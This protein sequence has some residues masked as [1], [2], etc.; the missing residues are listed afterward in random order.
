SLLIIEYNLDVVSAADW[1]IDIGPE[2]GARGGRLVAEGTPAQFLSDRQGLTADA[3]RQ[4]RQDLE[5]SRQHTGKKTVRH[6]GQTTAGK[7]RKILPVIQI[8]H[9]REHNLK[10]IDLS[11]PWNTFTVITGVS[12]SGKSTIAFDIIFAEG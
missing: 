11:V 10:N 5:Q 7:T 2:G 1:L 8:R 4:Y 12:G 9:A 3:L 6:A